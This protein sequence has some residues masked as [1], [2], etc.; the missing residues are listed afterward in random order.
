MPTFREILLGK[1][2]P[3]PTMPPPLSPRRERTGLMKILLGPSKR[4]PKPT[5]PPLSP[6]RERTGLMKILL[7]PSKPAPVLVEEA[8]PTPEPAA[9]IP[10]VLEPPVGETPGDAEALPDEPEIVADAPVEPE[11]PAGPVGW[12]PKCPNVIWRVLQPWVTPWALPWHMKPTNLMSDD[13]IAEEARA[14]PQLL[15]AKGGFDSALRRPVLMNQQYVRICQVAGH[16]PLKPFMVR[17][18]VAFGLAVLGAMFFAN[19]MGGVSDAKTLSDIPWYVVPSIGFGVGLFAGMYIGGTAAAVMQFAKAYA[20]AWFYEPIFATCDICHSTG[21]LDDA[22][23]T[24]DEAV[25]ESAD[26]EEADDEDDGDEPRMVCWHCRGAGEVELKIAREGGQEYVLRLATIDNPNIIYTGSGVTAG[27]LTGDLFLKAPRGFTIA[28]MEN[29]N[30]LAT[31]ESAKG[32]YVG[33]N[34]RETRNKYMEAEEAGKRSLWRTKKPIGQY[35]KE[36]PGIVALVIGV[37]GS[38]LIFTMVNDTTAQPPPPPVPAAP[39]VPVVPAGVQPAEGTVPS[40]TTVPTAV[41][42]PSPALSPEEN[43]A[44]TPESQ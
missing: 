18:G 30:V 7:G 23:G 4:R 34:D 25:D 29:S 37:V 14:Q 1:P 8:L 35:L 19:R 10:T 32:E 13:E 17:Y 5:M 40:P 6:L 15:R 11:E 26:G 9:T 27:F 39:V 3:K 2:R 21:F 38:V 24:G 28:L 22:D 16:L 33:E 12:V 44:P 41:P 31:W 20:K 43:V 42:G 36:W